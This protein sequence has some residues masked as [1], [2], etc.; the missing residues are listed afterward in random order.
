MHYAKKCPNLAE[1]PLGE[2]ISTKYRTTF[3]D[4]EVNHHFYFTCKLQEEIPGVAWC[5]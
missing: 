3:D 1:E 5:W 4:K 2:T